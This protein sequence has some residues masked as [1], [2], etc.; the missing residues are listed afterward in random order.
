MTKT[1]VRFCL[2]LLLAIAHIGD[3]S[4]ISPSMNDSNVIF[5][6]ELVDIWTE[7]LHA[8]GNVEGQGKYQ[9][10]VG[11]E[12]R[13]NFVGEILYFYPFFSEVRPSSAHVHGKKYEFRLER[14]DGSSLWTIEHLA[15]N[16]GESEVNSW[17]FPKHHDSPQ[18]DIV[19]YSIFNSVGVGLFTEGS[20]PNLPDIFQSDH[21][22]IIRMENIITDGK[23]QILLEFE[24]SYDDFPEELKKKPHFDYKNHPSWKPYYMKAEVILETDYYLISQGKFHIRWLAKENRIETECK[25]DT[26]TYRVPLPVHYKVREQ[27]RDSERNLALTSEMTIDFDLRETNPKDMKRFTLSAFGLPE[28]DFEPR[29]MSLFRIVMMA[30]GG[31]IIFVALWR[32]WSERKEDNKP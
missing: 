20:T 25:F 3:V 6:Q 26:T 27:L 2:A 4:A 10:K 19:G 5:K 32:V 24:Y 31:I 11:D 18:A 17:A 28:P 21:L 23:K 12:V 22:K 9:Y 14:A 13:S 29:R 7:Y 15:M 8:L 1:C 30:L 16:S